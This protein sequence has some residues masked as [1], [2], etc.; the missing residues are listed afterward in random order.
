MPVAVTPP[1]V[2]V[3]LRVVVARSAP[4][5]CCVA[6]LLNESPLPT[7]HGNNVPDSWIVLPAMGKTCCVP[8]KYPMVRRPA[9]SFLPVAATWRL[10]PYELRY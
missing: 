6:A 4:A 10:D 7:I 3:R 2:L 9:D 1:T 5:N 8:L